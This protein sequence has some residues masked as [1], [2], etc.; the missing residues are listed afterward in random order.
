MTLALGADDSVTGSMTS[1]GET[2]AVQ[3]GTYRRGESIVVLKV[4]TPIGTLEPEFKLVDGVLT[5]T[6]T[7]EDGVTIELRA[8]KQ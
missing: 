1:E 4:N 2:I 5:A 3:S 7:I 8:V 6:L